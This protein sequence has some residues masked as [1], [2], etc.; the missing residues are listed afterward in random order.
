MNFTVRLEVGLISDEKPKKKSI[1]HCGCRAS[2]VIHFTPCQG[3][4]SFQL[5]I[6]ANFLPSYII[7]KFL[8]F[9][10][11]QGKWSFQLL[12]HAK[13]LPSYIIS[14]FLLHYFSILLYSRVNLSEMK[15]IWPCPRTA[16][17]IIASEDHGFEKESDI[18]IDWSLIHFGSIFIE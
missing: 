7:S 3:K 12:I 8:H 11:C 5:L 4:W 17:T 6:H 1:T 2:Q 9:T 18:H 14:K 13:F 10:P 16:K 15:L